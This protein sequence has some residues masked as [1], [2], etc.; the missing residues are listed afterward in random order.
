MR[1]DWMSWLRLRVVAARQ[2]EDCALVAVQLEHGE[3][4]G[5]CAGCDAACHQNLC[6]ACMTFPC[7]VSCIKYRL[8]DGAV[9]DIR[10]RTQLAQTDSNP[11][12]L[13]RPRRRH[14]SRGVSSQSW[15]LKRCG[16]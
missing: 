10:A 3:W 8:R 14:L 11:T 5:L 15:Y 9:R 16:T 13:T 6:K 4:S 12:Q 1:L 2:N 7:V